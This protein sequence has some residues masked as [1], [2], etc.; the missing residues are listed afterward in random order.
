MA[1]AQRRRSEAQ[2]S[3]GANLMKNTLSPESPLWSRVLVLAESMDEPGCSI[4]NI[5]NLLCGLEEGFADT[6]DP[7]EDFPEY[8][9][10][11]LC[12][13]LRRLLAQMERQAQL[14]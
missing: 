12:G 10:H 13:S 9:T 4:E 5:R 2:S 6:F 1:F 7:A 8:A 3:C 14:Q 11:R